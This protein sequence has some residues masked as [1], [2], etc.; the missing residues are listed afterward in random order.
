MQREAECRVI[1]TEARGEP[2]DL[3]DCGCPHDGQAGDVL[4]RRE[5][6][7]TQ[8]DAPVRP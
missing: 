4:E 5:Y 2:Y 6:A 8:L 7:R 1:P 3:L